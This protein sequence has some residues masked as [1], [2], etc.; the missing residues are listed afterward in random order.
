MEITP[1]YDAI[2]IRENVGVVS[3]AIYFSNENIINKFQSV[4]GSSM[5]LGYAPEGIGIL[6][7]LLRSFLDLTSIKE[8][9]DPFGRFDL[10]DL[11]SDLMDQG[12]ERFD[13]AVKGVQRPKAENLIDLL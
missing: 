8:I 12:I 1:G 7:V 10:A 6:H 11:G 3:D 13:A 2:I 4:I 5:D 9:T